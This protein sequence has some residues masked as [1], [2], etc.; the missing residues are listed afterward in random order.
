MAFGLCQWQY[1]V[2]YTHLD[3]YKRQLS[4][5]EIV[6]GGMEHHG[7]ASIP[8]YSG[9]I[10]DGKLVVETAESAYKGGRQPNIPIIIGSNSAED[11]YK[12]QVL[13]ETN[14]LNASGSLTIIFKTTYQF[15]VLYS[16]GEVPAA[17]LNIRLK[18]CGYLNPNS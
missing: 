15:F 17:F 6:D 8:I 1:S 13:L 12:R 4:V 18:C 16:L 11:V 10:F 7:S 3:V 9:P 14:S 2:S 5:E